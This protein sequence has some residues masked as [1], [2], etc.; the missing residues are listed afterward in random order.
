MTS[1]KKTNQVD[2]K[3]QIKFSWTLFI[4]IKIYGQYKCKNCIVIIAETNTFYNVIKKINAI[5]VISS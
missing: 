5:S 1:T 2:R 3:T 4:K